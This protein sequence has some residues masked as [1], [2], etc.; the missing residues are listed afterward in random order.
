MDSESGDREGGPTWRGA[1]AVGGAGLGLSV[2]G[3]GQQHRG[4]RSA[5]GKQA[6]LTA[7]GFVC[8]T[9]EKTVC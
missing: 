3:R 2:G 5:V 4:L 1:A 6:V 9:G 7:E 8:G